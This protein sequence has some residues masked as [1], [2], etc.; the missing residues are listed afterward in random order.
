ML[1]FQLWGRTFLESFR[2]HTDPD[3]SLASPESGP[4]STNP[5]SNTSGRNT[6]T[7][8]RSQPL[9][10]PHTRLHVRRTTGQPMEHHH[11]GIEGSVTVHCRTNGPIQ[12]C[13]GRGC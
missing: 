11:P 5:S 4:A 7:R 1:L 2:M 10:Y 12:V 3:S 6:S 13:D 8:D 9:F